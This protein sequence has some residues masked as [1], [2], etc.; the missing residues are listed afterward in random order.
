MWYYV[1]QIEEETE[2]PLHVVSD[3]YMLRS[4]AQINCN[5]RKMNNSFKRTSFIVMTEQ[6]VLEEFGLQVTQLALS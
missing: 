6:E 3:P 1:V 5:M 4:T 2:T